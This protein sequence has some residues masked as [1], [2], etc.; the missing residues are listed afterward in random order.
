[1]SK[2]SQ[3][4]TVTNAGYRPVMHSQLNAYLFRVNM[5][6]SQS[7]GDNDVQGQKVNHSTFTDIL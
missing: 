6:I 2:L 7:E 1:M 5:L 3:K 4:Q